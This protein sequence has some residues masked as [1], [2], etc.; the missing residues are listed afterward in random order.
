VIVRPL[1]K[2]PGPSTVN[3]WRCVFLHL[4]RSFPERLAGTLTED[5]ARQWANGLGTDK[6]KPWTVNDVW[7]R[8]AR[9]VFAWAKEQRLVGTNPFKG[10]RVTEPRRHRLRETKAFTKDEARTILQAALELGSPTEA[11]PAACRWVPWLSAYSGA[12]AGEMCQLRGSDVIQRDGIH[13]IRITPEAGTT[14]TGR[15]RIVPIH[16]HLIDQGF[17]EFVASRGKGPLFYVPISGDAHTKEEQE[18]RSQD[19]TNPKRPRPVIARKRL[20]QWVR[21]LGITDR[22][23]SPTHAWRHTFKA[24]AA[25]HELSETVIDAITG[26]TQLTIGRGYAVPTLE[27]MAKALQ[28][29][30]R[31]VI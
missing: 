18:L 31:Y 23:L 7:I 13:A 9:T 26:H 10:V 14:K 17:L 8:A 5:E 30:P 16:E 4:E 19:P 2:Q 29:F 15:P 22:E 3:R 24:T 25:R 6:R 11:F 20:A 21:D 28:R 27:D 12:R 1:T